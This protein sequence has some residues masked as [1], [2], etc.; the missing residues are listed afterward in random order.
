MQWCGTSLQ[1][2]LGEWQSKSWSGCLSITRQHYFMWQILKFPYSI[3]LSRLETKN[4]C[5]SPFS[6]QDELNL[7]TRKIDISTKSNHLLTIGS[8]QWGARWKMY[9]PFV[10]SVIFAVLFPERMQFGHLADRICMLH[11]KLILR[12]PLCLLIAQFLQSHY[13]QSVNNC[14]L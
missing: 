2:S 12:I 10:P 9:Q 11:A 7:M 6:S 1:R 13:L 4:K 8:K 14:R 5:T 3:C